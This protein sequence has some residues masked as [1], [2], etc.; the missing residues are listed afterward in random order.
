[1]PVY[2]IRFQQLTS[3]S[4]Y[5]FIKEFARLFLDGVDELDLPS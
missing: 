2:K 4:T 1:M 3:V 5:F